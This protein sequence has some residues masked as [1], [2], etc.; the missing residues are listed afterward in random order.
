M[1]EVLR[2]KAMIKCTPEEAHELA[3]KVGR[4]FAEDAN[5]LNLALL[6]DLAREP[7][8]ARLEV[9]EREHTEFFDRWHDERRKREAGE[10]ERD[11]L[12]AQVKELRAALIHHQEQTRPIFQTDEALAHTAPDS[13]DGE[14]T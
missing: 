4:A 6:I 8:A 10:L 13:V 9:L 12:A 14:T 11:A 3:G 7:M 5:M 2:K 1:S